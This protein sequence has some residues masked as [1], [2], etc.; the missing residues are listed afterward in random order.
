MKAQWHRSGRSGSTTSKT[1]GKAHRRLQCWSGTF[2]RAQLRTEQRLWFCE[3]P[4]SASMHPPANMT[5]MI[6][7]TEHLWIETISMTKCSRHVYQTQH[8]RGLKC[9]TQVSPSRCNDE[10]KARRRSISK[11]S[12][13]NHRMLAN[14]IFACKQ[15]CLLSQ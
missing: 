15:L 5:Q 7:I 6:S 4:D 13:T 14:M 12:Q 10:A 8:N 9:Q 1:C 2:A 3:V 11:T